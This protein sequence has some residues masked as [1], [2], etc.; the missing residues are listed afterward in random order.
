MTQLE[1][2]LEMLHHD[3]N[4]GAIITTSR[5][6]NSRRSHRHAI[7]LTMTVLLLATVSMGCTKTVSYT[8][9]SDDLSQLSQEQADSEPLNVSV[10]CRSEAS[11][12]SCEQIRISQ[13]DTLKLVIP[14]RPQQALTPFDF[15]LQEGR[16]QVP[17]GRRPPVDIAMDSVDA[18][19]VEKSSISKGRIG[20]SFAA[21]PATGLA[22]AVLVSSSTRS[23]VSNSPT[24]ASSGAPF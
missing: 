14:Y 5:A 16:I 6:R 2:E 7:R 19:R 10:D 3:A 4:N 24:L 17:G 21:I 23:R 12:D 22:L 13:S 8:I 20:A 18:V 9:S 15:E 11:Q 1:T